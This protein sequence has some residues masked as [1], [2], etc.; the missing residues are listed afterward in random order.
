MKKVERFNKK[1]F[2]QFLTELMNDPEYKVGVARNKK[3]GMELKE[4]YPT[5]EFRNWCRKIAEKFGMDKKEAEYI[6]SKDF[7]FDNS[8]GLYDFFMSAVYDYMD[9]G[10]KV[11]LIPREDFKGSLFLRDVPD[12]EIDR[13]HYNPQDRVLLGL[14]KEKKKKHK[15][16]RV[17]SGCPKYLK[18]VIKMDI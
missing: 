4:I 1:K 16:I 12:K 7:K 18:E 5:K 8:E 14:F 15:E 17:K 11:D 9:K 10:N 6:M 2:N 13:K 3:S